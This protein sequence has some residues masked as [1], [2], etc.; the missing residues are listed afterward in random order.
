MTLPDCVLFSILVFLMP[1]ND[2]DDIVCDPHL[3]Q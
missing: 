2:I 3:I 1:R